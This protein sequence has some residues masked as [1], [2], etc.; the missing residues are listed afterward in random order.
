MEKYKFET[1]FN[2]CL[3]KLLTGTETVEQCLQRY[4]NYAQ[5]LEPLLRTAVSVNKAVDIKPSPEL[6]ARVRYKLQLKMAEAGK[7]RHASW[8]SVQ[9]RW[10]MS[11]IAVMLVFVMGGGAV[12]AADSSIPG[13]LLYPVK[14]LTENIS[15]KF[16]GSDVEKAELSM[17]FADRRVNEMNHMMESGKFNSKDVEAIASRYIGYVDQ[18]SSLSLGEQ[19]APLMGVAMMQAP[20]T[21]PAPEAPAT[22][23]TET[24][25]ALVERAPAPEIKLEIPGEDTAV[26]SEPSAQNYAVEGWDKL[27]QMIMFYAYYHPKQLEKWLESPK[28]PEQHKPAIRRMIQDLKD[29]ERRQRPNKK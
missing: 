23:P 25:K 6:K 17:A 15:I 29:L 10:A 3:E 19:T 28:V 1:I 13:S 20:S 4:P 7:P 26:V 2:E 21:A 8:L 14:I 11:M 24:Q 27:N 18:V 9:P 16:A 22:A 12:L 5:E